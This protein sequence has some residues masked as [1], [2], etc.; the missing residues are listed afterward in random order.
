MASARTSPLALPPIGPGQ[1]FDLDERGL[2]EATPDG[3]L[4]PDGVLVHAGSDGPR[5]APR[6]PFL[7]DSAPAPTQGPDERQQ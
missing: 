2:V 5:P 7:S 3:A 6:P 1:V 4:T